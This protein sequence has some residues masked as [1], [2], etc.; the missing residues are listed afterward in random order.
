MSSNQSGEGEIRK[1]IVEADLVDC[2]VA[3]PGQLFY[4][5]QIPVCLWFLARDKAQRPVPRP[6]RRDAV[7]RRPQAGH[8]D[9]PRPPRA[10]RRGHRQDRRHLP[11]LARRPTPTAR[12]ASTPDVPGFCKAATL[13]EIRAHGHVLTPGRYVGAEEVEDDGEPFEEKM[14][15]LVAQ[16]REQH[17]R[18]RQAGRGHRGQ[19]GG[20]GVWS[21]GVMSPTTI[22]RSLPPARD[23]ETTC[24]PAPL[25]RRQPGAGRAEGRRQPDPQPGHPDQRHPP[26]GGPAELGDREHRDHAGRALPAAAVEARPRRPGDEG[27]VALSDGAAAAA[28]TRCS[29]RRPFDIDLMLEVC[30]VLRDGPARLRDEEPILIEDVGAGPVVYTPPRG[31]AT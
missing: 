14:A 5:T 17:G 28:T 21:T 8:A 27:G 12:H 29:R 11:R 3:L 7:H 18:G 4:S 26:A 25:H 1:A 13:D 6:P 31:R 9:R 16:L 24:R 22:C 30:G 23:L 19:P 10:D 20:V 2:M 15:R